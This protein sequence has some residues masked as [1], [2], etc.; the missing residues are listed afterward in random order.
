MCCSSYRH[1]PSSFAIVGM[2]ALALHGQQRLTGCL[3]QGMDGKKIPGRL[4]MTYM[5][6]HHNFLVHERD[7]MAVYYDGDSRGDGL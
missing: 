4:E 1:S 7:E 6:E 5:E 3:W 2:C